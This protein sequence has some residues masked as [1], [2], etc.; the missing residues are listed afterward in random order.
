M[1]K[2]LRVT[3]QSGSFRHSGECSPAHAPSTMAIERGRVAKDPYIFSSRPTQ[4]GSRRMRFS[5]FPAV[6]RGK[7]SARTC[8]A[9]RYW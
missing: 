9:A 7:S 3:V 2:C 6:L 8:D 4:S 5:V 1:A